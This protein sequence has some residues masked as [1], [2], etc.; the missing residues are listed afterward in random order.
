MAD[1]SESLDYGREIARRMIASVR[2]MLR[3]YDVIL[4]RARAETICALVDTCDELEACYETCDDSELTR[5]ITEIEQL[6]ALLSEEVGGCDR[7]GC[8]LGDEEL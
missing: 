8:I 5:Y 7:G 1:D 4:R 3:N 6:S 2:T